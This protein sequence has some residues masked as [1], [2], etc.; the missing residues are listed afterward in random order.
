MEQGVQS[1]T[2]PLTIIV[3]TLLHTSHLLII[4]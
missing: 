1:R 4:R 3:F 2:S